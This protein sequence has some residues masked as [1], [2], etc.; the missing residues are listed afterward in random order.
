MNN[1]QLI[2]SLIHIDGVS[3]EEIKAALEEGEIAGYK[4]G[5][6]TTGEDREW[7]AV[8]GKYYY[9]TGEHRELF[10]EEQSPWDELAFDENGLL[11]F[12]D[13]MMKLRK[14]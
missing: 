9:D 14:I 5:L 8:D 12:G 10:G 2:A 6:F 13:G 11:P 3:E 1:N 4:D 7:K